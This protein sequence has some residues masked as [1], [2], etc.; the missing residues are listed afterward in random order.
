MDSPKAQIEDF[1][2]GWRLKAAWGSIC[3]VNLACALDATTV[4]VAIPVISASIHC[5]SIEALWIGTAFL[6]ASTVFQ[7]S[8]NALSNDLGR[9]PVLLVALT[10]FTIGAI[11]CGVAQAST[12]MLVGRTVQGAGVAG[13]LTLTSALI[14]DLIPL[15]HRGNYFALMSIVWAVGTIAGKIYVLFINHLGISETGYRLFK[16]VD[17]TYK[18]KANRSS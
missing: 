5:T 4:S 9:K 8:F 17:S 18:D 7:P 1:N 10:L 3:I 16:T 6:L 11:L 12:L 13:I 2:P 15:R 14:T